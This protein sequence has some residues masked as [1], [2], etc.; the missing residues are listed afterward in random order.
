MIREEEIRE[1]AEKYLEGSSRYLV[2]VKVKPGNKILVFIDGDSDVSIDDCVGLSRHIE[3]NIDRDLEDYELNVSSSGLDQPLRLKRQYERH[4]GKK[5]TVLDNNGIKKSG[6][7]VDITN[8]G[9][10]FREMKT[11]K[12]RRVID[13]KTIFIPFAEIKETK[14]IISFKE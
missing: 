9:I 11:I 10:T 4:K 13:K 7:L 3:Q 5:I 12:K 14:L 2:E 8:E 6:I 1:L